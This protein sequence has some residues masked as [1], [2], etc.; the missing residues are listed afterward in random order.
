[1]TVGTGPAYTVPQTECNG[2]T[3]V[4]LLSPRISQNAAP[5]VMHAS[6]V[7]FLP[8]SITSRSIGLVGLIDQD[9]VSLPSANIWEIEKLRTR[10][11]LET[12][13]DMCPAS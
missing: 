12:L 10:R 1:M 3:I 11:P 5:A 13:K 6:A 9:P 4:M 2:L 8:W 7:A